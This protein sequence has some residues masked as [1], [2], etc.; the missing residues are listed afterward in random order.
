MLGSCSWRLICICSCAVV[1]FGNRLS[2]VEPAQR[3]GQGILLPR[4]LACSAAPAVP[5]AQQPR[6]QLAALGSRSCRR[7]MWTDS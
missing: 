1:V 4:A 7:Q 2:A 5:C 6:V 3:Y